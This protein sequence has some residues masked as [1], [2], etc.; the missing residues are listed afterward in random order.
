MSACPIQEADKQLEARALS[1]VFSK[2]TFDEMRPFALFFYMQGLA[3]ARMRTTASGQDLSNIVNNHILGLHNQ[4][5]LQANEVQP[6]EGGPNY[7][8]EE[9]SA[10]TFNGQ[11]QPS[12]SSIADNYSYLQQPGSG[13][14][15]YGQTQP[16]ATCSRQLFI[17]QTTVQL[18]IILL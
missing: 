17:K 8:I 16:A 7:S 13:T 2:L 5:L 11:T 15:N 10:G 6:Q 18:L 3:D 4:L 12:A 1:V 14:L 9:G